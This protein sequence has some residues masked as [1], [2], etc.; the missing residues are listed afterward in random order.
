MFVNAFF[1]R[2]TLW[3]SL[4]AA[5]TIVGCSGKSTPCTVNFV[6]DPELGGDLVSPASGATAVPDSIGTLVVQAEGNFSIV[7]KANDGSGVTVQTTPT[8]LPSAYI[9]TSGDYAVSVPTLQAGTS[10]AVGTLTNDNQCAGNFSF[11]N[12]GTFTTQ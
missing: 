3:C 1:N 2:L 7:L 8:A 5:V 12:F 6:L 4:F 9:G 11:K 10:Y